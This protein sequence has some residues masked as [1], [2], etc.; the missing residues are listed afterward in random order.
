VSEAVVN[1]SRRRCPRCGSRVK[2]VLRTANDKRRWDADD[3]RRYRCRSDGCGWQDLL[4]V[5][6]DRQGPRQAA[7]AASTLLRVL[8]AALLLL[9][10]GGLAWGAMLLLEFLISAPG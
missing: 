3:W 2:R 7:P 5:S 6:A 8:R 4:E 9:A 10:A 1:L